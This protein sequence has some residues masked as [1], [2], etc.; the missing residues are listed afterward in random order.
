M[1]YF[2]FLL[3]IFLTITCFYFAVSHINFHSAQ[4]LF[5]SENGLLA[6]VIGIMIAFIQIILGAIRFHLLIKQGNYPIHLLESL[7]ISFIGGFFSQVVFSFL[8]GDAMRVWYLTQ[9]KLTFKTAT[10]LVVLDRALGLITL[11]FLCLACLPIA[12]K[13]PFFP[14]ITNQPFVKLTTI[15]LCIV[16]LISI[17]FILK[18]KF[19]N[20]KTQ[21]NSPA[22]SEFKSIFES[23]VKNYRFFNYPWFLKVSDFF[24]FSKKT[25]E[26]SFEHTTLILT[27]SIF[28]HLCNV[29]AI[30]SFMRC[31]EIPIGLT[32][33]AIVVI[34]SM[35]MVM[36]PISVGGWG[37]RENLF[38]MGFGFFNIPAEFSLAASILLGITLVISLLPGSIL[39]LHSPLLRS[40]PASKSQVSPV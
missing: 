17:F 14:L 36:M 12:C 13:I 18:I 29:I 39:F 37:I 9:S 22:K 25:L 31:F 20:S 11:C 34:P 3:K 26:K 27:L 24:S 30:Y 33:C 28:V 6:L 2:L 35:L 32:E 5:Y 21:D 8:S 15:F 40:V 23:T 38:I 10:H 19:W 7:K 16:F 1:K 4:N